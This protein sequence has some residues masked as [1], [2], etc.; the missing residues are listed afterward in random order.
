[1][2][3]Q[4]IGGLVGIFAVCLIG[5]D[6]PWPVYAAGAFLGAYGVAWLRAR[7]K[8]GRGISVAPSMPEPPWRP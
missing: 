7:V 2:F 5:T 8:Y 1:M 4:L 3:L 6:G